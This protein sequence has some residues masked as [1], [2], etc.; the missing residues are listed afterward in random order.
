[1][2]FIMRKALMIISLTAFVAAAAFAAPR[3]SDVPA[4]SPTNDEIVILPVDDPSSD[5]KKYAP[6]SSITRARVA[7]ATSRKKTKNN[8]N[9]VY[10]A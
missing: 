4:T 6:S 8:L 10:Y 1:M 5:S 2:E 3:N 7:D 9:G